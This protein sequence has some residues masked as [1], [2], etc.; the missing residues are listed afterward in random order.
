MPC[1]LGIGV[2]GNGALAVGVAYH[3]GQGE[4]RREKEKRGKKLVRGFFKWTLKKGHAKKIEASL[5]ATFPTF[6]KK[7]IHAV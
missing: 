4:S 7:R 6:R 3:W 2:V 5:D 1:D